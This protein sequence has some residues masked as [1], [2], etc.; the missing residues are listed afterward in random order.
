MRSIARLLLTIGGLA[1]LQPALADR[2]S[3]ENYYDYCIKYYGTVSADIDVADV[4]PEKSWNGN[5]TCPR[6]W[7]LASGG[8]ASLKLCPPVLE[9]YGNDGMDA[10]AINVELVYN[11][12]RGENDL[13]ITYFTFRNMLVTNGTAS[14]PFLN[15]GK[16]AILLKGEDQDESS[17]PIWRING[18]E[19]SLVHCPKAEKCSVDG[20]IARLSC[21]TQRDNAPWFQ[22]CG[23]AED[24]DKLAC[25]DQE[26][27]G[28]NMHWPMNFSIG[29]D[30]YK[31]KIQLWAR[32][33]TPR[34]P[35]AGNRS[36]S[37]TYLEFVGRREVPSVAEYKFWNNTDMGYESETA[38]YEK[39]RK[40][41]V[42]PDGQGY[43]LFVNRSGNGEWYALVNQTFSDSGGVMV[44]RRISGLAGTFAFCVLWMVL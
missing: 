32:S 27:I 3:P 35:E 16:P 4:V 14:G 33:K 7:E 34:Y 10:A 25:W 39:S 17:W 20:G 18:T 42:V 15:D 19:K 9:W 29:F 30:D 37:T 40:M 1:Q 8:G 31:A 43:P 26:E 38:K 24:S 6:R 21:W 23:F 41:G 28:W 13:D 5:R 2:P 22:Y 44:E 36:F 12:G 11:P